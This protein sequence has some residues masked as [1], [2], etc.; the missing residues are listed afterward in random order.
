M[1]PSAEISLEVEHAHDSVFADIDAMAA[2]ARAWDQ[3]YE[4]IGRG[5]FQG[6]LAQVILTTL[7]LGRVLWTTGVLQRGS[8]PPEG[9]TIGL[10][11]ATNG[12]LHIRGRPVAM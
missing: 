9:W 11:I 1:P 12:S 4:Q 7:Q 8:A 5:Q 10:P 6:R 2:S 3:H